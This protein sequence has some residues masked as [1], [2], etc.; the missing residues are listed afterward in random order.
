MFAYFIANMDFKT[1]VQL[2]LSKNVSKT[3]EAH[4]PPRDRSFRCIQTKGE[5]RNMNDKVNLF[6]LILLRIMVF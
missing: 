1:S 5:Q 2:Q 3:F 4:G 6:H